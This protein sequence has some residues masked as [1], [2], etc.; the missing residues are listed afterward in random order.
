MKKICGSIELDDGASLTMEER[1]EVVDEIAKIGQDIN[2]RKLVRGLNIRAA[3]MPNWQG[4]IKR[5]A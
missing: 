5:Y 4:L 2:I 1:L 3:G